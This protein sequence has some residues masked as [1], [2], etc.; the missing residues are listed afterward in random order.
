MSHSTPIECKVA[1][2]RRSVR[3]VS[4]AFW[5]VV[6]AWSLASARRGKADTARRRKLMER[7]AGSGKPSEHPFAAA[8]NPAATSM[9]VAVGPRDRQG[10]LLELLQPDVLELDPH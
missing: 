9:E 2:T 3:T 7:M 1:C 5:L 10:H 4:L 6:S 8:G